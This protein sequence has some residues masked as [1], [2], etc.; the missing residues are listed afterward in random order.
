MRDPVGAME[1]ELG[2]NWRW[3]ELRTYRVIGLRVMLRSTGAA[4]AQREAR[5]LGA[6]ASLI[7][8]SESNSRHLL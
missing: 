4:A 5:S 6:S 7:R 1:M 3:P 8:N 2:L